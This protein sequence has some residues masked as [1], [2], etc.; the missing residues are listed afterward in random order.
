VFGLSSSAPCGTKAILRP[1]EINRNVAHGK[2]IDKPGAPVTPEDP[3]QNLST[4]GLQKPAKSPKI[5]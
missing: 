4:K 1:S 5:T 2:A 3:L